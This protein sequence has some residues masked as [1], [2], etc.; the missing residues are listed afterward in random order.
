MIKELLKYWQA[1]V[2]NSTCMYNLGY[3]Y[4]YGDGVQQNKNT[5]LEWYEKAAETGYPSAMLKVAGYRYGENG[6][7]FKIDKDEAWRLFSDA[8]LHGDAG[9]M[10]A[11]AE[12]YNGRLYSDTEDDL[13]PELVLK[14]VGRA[15]S[16]SP[17]L[18]SYCN[19]VINGL[20]KGEKIDRETANQIVQEQKEHFILP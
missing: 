12:Y 10:G 9:A 7:G 8:A 2:L 13:D 18:E 1:L 4:E 19:D 17:N 20:I 16:I 5:A 11:I 6:A 14:W 15:L 3:C